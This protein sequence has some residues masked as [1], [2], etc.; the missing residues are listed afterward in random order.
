MDQVATASSL[1]VVY[2]SALACLQE[3]LAVGRAAGE[4]GT[5]EWDIASGRVEWSSELELIHGIE[6]GT[7]GGDFEA[8]ERDMHPEDRAHARAALRRALE[9]ES[10]EYALEYRI[11]PPEGVVR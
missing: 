8:F 1:Q 9:G 6:P 10:D 4:L 7:F 3:T 2:E 11:V 5:W